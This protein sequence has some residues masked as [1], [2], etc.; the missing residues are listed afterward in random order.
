VKSEQELRSMQVT[1]LRQYA[2]DEGIDLGSATNKEDIVTS[3]L[4]AENGSGDPTSPAPNVP[5][6][7]QPEVA[8]QIDR[9][10][11]AADQDAQ[12]QNR[13]AEEQPTGVIEEVPV[14][15]IEQ[16]VFVRATGPDWDV[17]PAS[18]LEVLQARNMPIT[19]EALRAPKP[20]TD[21]APRRPAQVPDEGEV[22]IVSSIEQSDE[23]ES[24]P[25]EV[26]VGSRYSAGGIDP[27]VKGTEGTARS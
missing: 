21:A 2:N 9:K 8:G 26:G 25:A 20:A 5:L 19:T 14:A 23:R 16:A 6:T 12:L 18:V 7:G 11:A 17:M 13:S 10:S 22:K 3:I 27:R 15:A 24:E 1:Q 4:S